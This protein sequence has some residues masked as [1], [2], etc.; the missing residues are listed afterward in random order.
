MPFRSSAMQAITGTSPSSRMKASQ[1]FFTPSSYCLSGISCYVM[2]SY[3]MLCYVIVS[4]LML[5]YIMLCYVMLCHERGGEERRVNER[6]R[7][8]IRE[9]G[10]DV[11]PWSY[12]HEES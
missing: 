6:R 12:A 8:E 11:L 7:K 9:E 2:L 10:R 4:Y 3:V 1:C 5:C